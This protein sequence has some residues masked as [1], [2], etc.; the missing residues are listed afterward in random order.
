MKP[1]HYL[2]TYIIPN[3]CGLK[4]KPYLE[5]SD[6]WAKSQ[7]STTYL[8]LFFRCQKP[9]SSGSSQWPLVTEKKTPCFITP[10]IFYL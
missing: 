9:F 10:A 1:F 6:L 4:P 8:L 7:F 5:V 2:S 3:K